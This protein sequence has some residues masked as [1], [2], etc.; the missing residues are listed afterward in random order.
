[1]S[2]NWT[3]FQKLYSPKLAQTVKLLSALCELMLNRSN[4]SRTISI[5]QHVFAI[6]LF[7]QAPS[8]N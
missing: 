1:M 7:C 8:P 2:S 4:S 3:H 6:R 5:M